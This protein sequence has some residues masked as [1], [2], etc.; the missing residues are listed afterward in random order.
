MATLYDRQPMTTAEEVKAHILDRA[1][2]RAGAVDGPLRGIM[3]TDPQR[4]LV[5]H[6][7]GMALGTGEAGDV[8]RHQLLEYLFGQPSSKRL[9]MDE[10]GALIDWLKDP[11]GPGPHPAAVAECWLVLKAWG[12]KEGQ[13][14]LL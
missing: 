5:C 13:L 8:A 12:A 6:L 4:G 14:E 2:R 10:A 1:R 7:L 11:H 3:A 9:T